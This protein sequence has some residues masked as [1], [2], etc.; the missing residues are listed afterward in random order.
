MET[1]S[2]LFGRI[3]DI[4]WPLTNIQS[5]AMKNVK[6]LFSVNGFA[7]KI[8]CFHLESLHLFGDNIWLV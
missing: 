5:L 6:A 8:A 4:S 1:F 7:V 3:S 2:L